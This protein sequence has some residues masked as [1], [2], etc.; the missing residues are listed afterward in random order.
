[1]DHPDPTHAELARLL[2]EFPCSPHWGHPEL[3]SDVTEI[4]GVRFYLDGLM[5]SAAAEMSATGSAASVD[6]HDIDRAYFELVERTCLLDA[7]DAALPVR[8]LLDAAGNATGSCVREQA[9]PL[10]PAGARWAYA[11]SNG[12]AAGPDWASACAAA[13][14]EALERHHVLCAWYGYSVPRRH[15]LD[16]PTLRQLA[17]LYDFEAHEFPAPSNEA[18]EPLSVVGCFGFPKLREAP[19][20]AGFGAAPELHAAEQRAV[21]E[22]L[23]RLGF[24]WGEAIPDAEPTLAHTADYHQELYLWPPM[25][26]RVRAWLDG[27]H[28]GR[29]GAPLPS[30]DA[31]PAFI[32][33]T[34]EH[35]APRLRVAKL[36]QGVGLT[37]TFGL[38][39]PRVEGAAALGAHPIA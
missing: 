4:A 29:C 20:L 3:F 11:R 36:V 30:D 18:G 15:S 9:F 2:R 28:A 37:L 22:T 16:D 8:T 34:P 25:Q 26:A 13:Q 31:R 7:I 35:L 5:A 21:R 24:L 23:Q 12:V 17:S 6:G 32:D 1:M 38:G 10:A 19:F 39:H 33:I 27:A 14:A